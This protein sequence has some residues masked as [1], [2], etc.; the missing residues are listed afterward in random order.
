[1]N[2]L[3][4]YCGEGL[5]Y[6]GLVAAGA[7]VVGVDLHRKRHY[8][9]AFIQADY[10]SLDDRLMAFFDAHWASPPCLRDTDMRHAPRAKGLAH[11][12]LIRP[13]LRKLRAAGKPFVLENVESAD[14]ESLRVAGERVTVLCGSMFGLG[15]DWNGRRLHLE[16]HRKFLTNWPLPAPTG[17]AHVK[18]VVTVL[19]GHARIRS[20]SAGGRGTADFV[21]FPGGHRAAMGEAMG[22]DPSRPITCAGISDGIPPAYARYVAE[23]LIAHV[24]GR[25]LAA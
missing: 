9:G 15:V 7:R 5:V 17:C 2:I 20:K 10:L 21:G 4:G 3:D 1:M 16:R 23:Q 18:P 25:R 19:G 14:L 13:T 22:I 24:S 12:E 11:P 6:D 8:P